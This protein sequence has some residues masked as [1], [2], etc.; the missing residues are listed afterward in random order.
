[1]PISTRRDF[2][3]LAAAASV[4]CAARATDRSIHGG[5]TPVIRSPA[6]GQS[7]RYAKHDYFTG[8][9]VDTQI[10]RVSK[11][12]ESIEIESRSETAED[13]PITY[14]S[15]GESWWRKYMPDGCGAQRGANRDPQAVGHGRRRSALERVAVL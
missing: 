9:V 4:G 2:L 10:D 14:P 7:W 1:M 12:G 5:P 3:L 8:K 13:Q 15:W 11:I 6:V